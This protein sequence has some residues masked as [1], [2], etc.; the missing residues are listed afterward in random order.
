MS[1]PAAKTPNAVLYSERLFPSIWIWLIAAGLAAACI[2]VFV[3]I[4]L[5]AGITAAVV[6]A[7]IMAVLLI[8]STPLIRV[9]PETLQ[10]GRAQIERR[11]I[12]KVEAF[13]GEDATLQRGP[14]LNATAYM[15]IRGWISPVVRMEITDP[16]DR[17]PYWLTSTRHPEKLVAALTGDR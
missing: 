6:A 7:I 3:P 11:Y 13:R 5:F 16:A 9:T 15:C 8:V 1:S 14:A 12:G 4:S 17:T 10:V 2:L